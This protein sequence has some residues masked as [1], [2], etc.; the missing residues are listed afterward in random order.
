MANVTTVALPAPCDA[1]K[2]R[3]R[4]W[5]IKY[6]HGKLYIGGVCSAEIS[7]NAND[8][9][10]SIYCYDGTTFSLIKSFPLNFTRG[11]IKGNSPTFNKW[12]AWED[13]YNVMLQNGQTD[14]LYP[15]P[16]LSDI[17]FDTDGSMI[18]GFTDRMGSQSAFRNYVPVPA[19]PFVLANGVTGGDIMRLCFKNNIYELE[20][21]PS[22]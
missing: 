12:L 6:W 19:F 18:L 3:F 16:I 9:T 17:E 14:F 8:L 5:A 7:K 13:N 11:I 2:S 22:A 15:Q 21:T 20:N 10:A 4:P 1:T